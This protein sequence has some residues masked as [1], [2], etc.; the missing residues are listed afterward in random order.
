MGIEFIVED[1]TLFVRTDEEWALLADIVEYM[2]EGRDDRL[3]R[4]GAFG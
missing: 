2:V 4:S 3:L 1:G